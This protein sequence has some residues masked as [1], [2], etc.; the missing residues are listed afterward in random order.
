MKKVFYQKCT[1][2]TLLEFKGGSKGV[3]DTKRTINLVAYIGC[4]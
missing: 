3:K 4:T 2:C 1:F